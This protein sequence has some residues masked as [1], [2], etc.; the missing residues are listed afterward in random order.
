PNVDWAAMRTE[1]REALGCP[2]PAEPGVEGG[3]DKPF[4]VR[5]FEIGN[6]TRRD[7]AGWLYARNWLMPMANSLRTVAR[8]IPDAKL[9]IGSVMRDNYSGADAIRRP[10]PVVW[11]EWNEMVKTETGTTSPD[12]GLCM[13]GVRTDLPCFD[14]WIWHYYPPGRSGGAAG[15]SF[16]RAGDSLSVRREIPAGTYRVEFTANRNGGAGGDERITVAVDDGFATLFEEAFTIAA[17]EARRYRSAGTF[18]LPASG[19]VTVRLTASGVDSPLNG[20]ISVYPLVGAARTD[21]PDPKP[22]AYFDLATAREA[23]L[24]Y[25]AGAL[26]WERV[27][28]DPSLGAFQNWVTEHHPETIPPSTVFVSSPNMQTALN[29]ALSLVTMVRS[30]VDRA[31]VW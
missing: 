24:A 14:A 12:S 31:Y 30:G 6:E 5:A 16:R 10:G 28:D 20:T 18:T 2:R 17:P 22:V 19:P 9:E 29:L 1:L 13:D 11:R 15:L 3:L 8:Q 4:L 25:M 27:F 21:G 26:Y 23:H 7:G